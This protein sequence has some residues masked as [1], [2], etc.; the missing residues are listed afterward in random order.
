MILRA[1]LSPAALI[2]IVLIIANGIGVHAFSVWKGAFTRGDVLTMNA[3]G[4]DSIESER[5][6]AMSDYLVKSHEEKLKA[7]KAIEQKK[8]AEIQALKDE[9][10]SIKA[11][12]KDAIIPEK[13]VPV[14]GS[15]E[16]LATKLV[17]YQKFMADYVVRAQEQ[18]LAAMKSVEAATIK[19]YEE[20][21]LL[22]KKEA[23][24]I[25]DT[26]KKESISSKKDS[27]SPP[28]KKPAETSEKK[29]AEAPKVEKPVAEISEKKVVEAPKVKK[30]AAE[31][32][33]K[34]VEP[35]KDKTTAV[36]SQK[37]VA[38]ILNDIPKEILD[39]DH[40]LR[41]DGGVGGPTLT[42]RV[43]LGASLGGN[44]NAVKEEVV[45]EVYMKRNKH[46]VKAGKAGKSRWGDREIARCAD[47]VEDPSVGKIGKA[48]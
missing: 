16:D 40:G 11:H 31:K 19:K 10:E 28:V 13:V 23:S 32:S 12:Q 45:D 14:D 24:S 15:V 36:D 26:R 3:G 22:L 9:I 34:V 47:L 2:A 18:K 42:E 39:A 8:D 48:P 6:K 33:E 27:P 35:Q 5:A 25:A 38:T 30:P 1:I 43:M 41:S 7:V 21:M 37:T 44:L 46:V 17:A 29:V 20:K 4:L